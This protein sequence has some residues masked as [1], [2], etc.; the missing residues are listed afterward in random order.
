MT[1]KD[2]KK[3]ILTQEVLANISGLSRFAYSL[4][5]HREEAKEF[6]QQDHKREDSPGYQ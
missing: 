1:E 2:L 4:C 5:Q 6:Y 3:E